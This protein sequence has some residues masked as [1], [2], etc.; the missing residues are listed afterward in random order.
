MTVQR[1][2]EEMS[3][4]EFLAWGVYFGILRQREEIARQ[5]GRG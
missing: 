3:Q 2:R 4:R 1:L 5:L